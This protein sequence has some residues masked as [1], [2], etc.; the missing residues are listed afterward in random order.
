MA[1]RRGLVGAGLGVLAAGAAVGALVERR[2]VGRPLRRAA[3]GPRGYGQV[4][5]APVVVRTDDGVELYAEVDPGRPGAAA[6]GLTVVLCHGY[7]L[8][9]DCWHYQ[10]LA[11]GGAVRLVLWDQR[12]H[13][14]SGR[15]P[16]GANTIDRLGEDL[17]TVL[18]ALV[19]EGPIVLVGHSM[20][21]MTVLSLADRHPQLFG[22][23]IVGVALLATSA[24]GIAEVTLGIPA[25]AARA[26]HRH[27]PTLLRALSG[28]P[29]L[30]ELG[31]RTGSDLEFLL[32]RAYSFASDVSPATVEFVT[33]MHAS[34]P[35]EVLAD[36]FP[37]FESHDKLSAIGVLD[38][39]DTLV[40]VGE[41]DRLTPAE[42]SRQIARVL[43][44]A[45]LR[46]VPDCGHMLML[47]HPDVVSLALRE[48]LA[49][50]GAARGRRR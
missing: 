28:R 34:T 48:Q 31:R 46:L 22:S 41:D 12:G 25:A 8:N 47:E 6:A 39:V 45:E 32:T 18:D 2:L 27:A 20:G 37:A 5:A 19:P 42:H 17:R 21:G 40:M 24:G 15:G 50:L 43:P 26:L 30:V 16:D 49:R 4:R 33:R 35:I 11:L 29:Q 10:R 1:G 44:A 7:A 3:E 23:R 14:R 36:F 38:R 9:L 13:G